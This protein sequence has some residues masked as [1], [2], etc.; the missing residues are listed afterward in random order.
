MRCGV[1]FNFPLLARRRPHNNTVDNPPTPPSSAP[2]GGARPPKWVVPTLAAIGVLCFGVALTAA[3]MLISFRQVGEKDPA[4]IEG[5]GP[6]ISVSDTGT[7]WSE[8]R[9]EDLSLTM[10]LP[11]RPKVGERL[12]DPA[13]RL[14][15]QAWA[16]YFLES[17]VNR[18]EISADVPRPGTERTVEDRAARDS[19]T[20]RSDV[21]ISSYKEWTSPLQVDGIRILKVLR[22]YRWKD[23]PVRSEN[24]YFDHRGKAIFLAGTG[25]S[26]E[27][28]AA[29]AEMSRIVGSLKALPDSSR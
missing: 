5:F 14:A 2:S 28:A 3:Y 29:Q 20:I 23:A 17:K 6:P 13:K 19:Q 11:G 15:T 7:G 8:F 10:E 24:Y 16:T 18:I 22:A 25:Y 26:K 27:S 9:F 21:E 4:P 1:E 12:W